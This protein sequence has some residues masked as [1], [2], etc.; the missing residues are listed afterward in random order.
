MKN[1]LHSLQHHFDFIHHHHGKKLAHTGKIGVVA[2]GVYHGA[3][4]L[5][6]HSGTLIAAGVLLALLIVKVATGAIE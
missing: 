6:A 2:E 5:G 4:L 3:E 1:Y